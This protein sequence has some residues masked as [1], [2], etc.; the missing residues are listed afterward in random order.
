MA[1][2]RKDT[3]QYLPAEKTIF[4]T[5]MLAD[6]Y[7]NLIGAANPTGMAVDAFGRARVTQPF[8][9]FDS[10]HRYF[11][12]GKLNTANSATG[13]TQFV[14]NSATINMNIDTANNAY[15][16]RESNRTFAYQPGKSLQILQ[17]FVMNPAKAGL[18]QRIGYFGA[19]NGYFLERNGT[20]IRFVERTSITGSVAD[21]SVERANWNIDKLDGTGPSGITLNLDNPQ[22]LFVDIEWLGAGT[23]RM[24]FVID[25]ELIHCHSFH[26]ANTN[27]SPKGPYLQTA[28]LPVRVEIENIA[29]TTSN[30]TMKVICSTVISEGGYELRGRNR[31]AHTPVSTAYSLATAGTYYP[32]VSVRLNTSNG[33]GDAIATLKHLSIAPVDTAIYHYKII[34]GGTITSNGWTATDSSSVVQYTVNASSAN[35][36]GSVE[37]TSGFIGATNQSSAAV[38]L[39]DEVFKYQMERDGFTN[40]PTPLTLMIS[41]TKASANVFASIDWQEVT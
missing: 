36:T 20:S 14:A 30:S 12:N 4:E 23:A 41:A 35:T 32:V 5:V 15:V 9:L 33:Y 3:H 31:T 34:S 2:F 7:G 38:A 22:I 19:N 26:H 8:T 11:D 17:S 21:D 39:T 10:S 13:N 37:L 6:Q 40:T 27:E 16:Y 24:G 1:Q 28:C 29:N 25:G 18:R